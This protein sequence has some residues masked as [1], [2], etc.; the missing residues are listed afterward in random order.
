MMRSKNYLRILEGNQIASHVIAT[1]KKL[2][3]KKYPTNRKY[4][5]FIKN[6]THSIIK[7]EKVVRAPKKP[8]P[9]ASFKLG[10]I[11][12]WTSEK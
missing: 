7:D 6:C 9:M 5:C 3:V 4:S 10:L 11:K 8:T 2:E 12:F 1:P